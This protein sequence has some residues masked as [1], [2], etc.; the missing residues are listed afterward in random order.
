MKRI[1]ILSLLLLLIVATS[2]QRRTVSRV[3]PDRTI[4]LSGRWNDTD[5]R[6]VAEEMIR[7]VL[8]RPWLTRF[9]TRNER[10]PVVIVGDIRNR[11]HEHIDGETFIR[12]MEREFV[13]TGLVRVVQS[14]EFREQMREERADQH[15]FADPATIAKWRRELGAD[16]M[17]TGTINSIVDQH[18]REKV[19]FYQVNLELS[20]METNEK[21]WIGEKQ[22]KKAVRN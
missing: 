14:A 9:E 22:L 1:T 18:G 20:D 8:S 19:I 12:N 16:F 6:L 11:T 10:Q 13:N 7:D 5:S 17:I 15:E 3:E 2:C 21:V 4:D